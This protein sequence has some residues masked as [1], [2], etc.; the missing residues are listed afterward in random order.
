M[1]FSPG[2]GWQDADDIIKADGLG[3]ALRRPPEGGDPAG[4]AVTLMIEGP[5]GPVQI[6]CSLDEEQCEVLIRALQESVQM[7]RDKVDPTRG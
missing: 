2:A 3:V 5:L 1:D 7:V 6:A 4:V